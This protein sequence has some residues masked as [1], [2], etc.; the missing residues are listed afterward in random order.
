MVTSHGQLFSVHLV[1]SMS[2]TID[3]QTLPAVIPGHFH[4]V[5]TPLTGDC[6]SACPGAW[7]DTP[8][9]LI[10]HTPVALLLH[11]CDLKGEWIT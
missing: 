4:V 7:F 3:A 10:S 11:T 1:L 9:S 8:V 5:T 2:V 6:V